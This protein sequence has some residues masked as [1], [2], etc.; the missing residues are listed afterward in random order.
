M[1]NLFHNKFEHTSPSGFH[2]R[3]TPSHPDYNKLM[4]K[5]NRVTGYDSGDDD[6]QKRANNLNWCCR[7][8]YQYN[9]IPRKTW[10]TVNKNNPLKMEWRKRACDN[11]IGGKGICKGKGKAWA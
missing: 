4:E 3:I 9:I 10:G 7:I 1:Y 2:I 11:L 5:I 8:G 6:I